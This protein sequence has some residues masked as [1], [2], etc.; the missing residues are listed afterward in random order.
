MMGTSLETC[1]ENGAM[2]T[3]LSADRLHQHICSR[4]MAMAPRSGQSSTTSPEVK[5]SDSIASVPILASHWVSDE[6]LCI[7]WSIHAENG[8]YAAR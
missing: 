6:V 1:P 4:D 7:Y 5:Q 3:H 2:A 8:P